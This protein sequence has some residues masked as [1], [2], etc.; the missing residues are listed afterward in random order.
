MRAEM[1]AAMAE[2]ALEDDVAV[3]VVEVAGCAAEWITTQESDDG[4]ILLYLH[5]GGYV[6]GSINTHRELVSRIARASAARVLNLDYR[7]APEY[8]FP[9]PVIDA[10]GAFEWLLG[11]GFAAERIGVAGDSAGGGLTLAMMLALKA[12]GTALPRLRSLPVTV[13]R[14]RGHR[15]VGSTGC[16]GRSHG[17]VGRASGDGADLRVWRYAQPAGGAAVRRLCRACRRC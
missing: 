16:G 15:R 8:P 1:E 13:D 9:A 5:G 3:E 2:Y 11:Q 6:M 12:Q 17:G 14:S 10:A 7:L 4:R